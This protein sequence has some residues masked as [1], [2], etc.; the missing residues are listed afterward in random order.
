MELLACGDFRSER[1]FHTAQTPQ[2]T[3]CVYEL[4]FYTE[5]GGTSF[6]NQ[7]AYPQK[8]CHLLLVRPG[9]QRFTVGKSRCLYAHFLPHAPLLEER[10]AELP[11]AF[12]L[13]GEEA[14]LFAGL[15][16]PF[17]GADGSPHATLIALAA[18][19]RILDLLLTRQGGGN[20]TGQ[21][22]PHAEGLLRAKV[23]METHY[24]E[25]LTLDTLCTL[26]HFSKN[27]FRVLFTRAF[28]LSP[29][30]YLTQ[31]RISSALQMRAEGGYTEKEIAY[32]CGFS[33]QSHMIHV[34]RTK[35]K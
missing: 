5:D 11:V 28:G 3:T 20:G 7:A 31:V 18:L 15:F 19:C 23:Y 14:A 22:L 30:E 25:H 29:A 26:A 1:Y 34:L 8:G 9:M 4:E 6:V 27:H 2:R 13:A 10:L 12:S 32:R 21:P 17:A 16:A 33:S 35:G 24:G